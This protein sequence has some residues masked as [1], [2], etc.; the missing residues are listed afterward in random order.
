MPDKPSA[1]IP[2]VVPIERIERRIYVIRGLKVMLDSD[3]AAL[4]QVETRALIQAVKRNPE[5][6][7]TDFMFQF[8]KEELENWRSQIVMS[9]PSAKM[10]L[11]RQPYAFTEHGVAML[12]SVLKSKRAVHMS[13]HIIRAFVAMRELLASHQDLAMRVEKIEASQKRHSSVIALLADEIDRLKEPPP[14]PPKGRMG[15][16]AEDE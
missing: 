7:P 16:T 15:F 12:S 1:R 14:L 8:S 11:R 9:N 2:S 13:I 10:G 3:L 6:F 5:R 4:Y